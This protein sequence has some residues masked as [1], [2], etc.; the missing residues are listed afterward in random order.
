MTSDMLSSIAGFVCVFCVGQFVFPGTFCKRHGSFQTG[1]HTPWDLSVMPPHGG[2]YLYSAPCCVLPDIPLS[3][4]PSP[5]V[6]TGAVG[7][8]QLLPI[9]QLHS[10]LCPDVHVLLLGRHMGRAEPVGQRFSG[11]AN[12]PSKVLSPPSVWAFRSSQ[13]CLLKRYNQT[14]TPQPFLWVSHG[15]PWGGFSLHVSDVESFCVIICPL[16]FF[17]GEVSV[18]IIYPLFICVVCFLT[19]DDRNFCISQEYKDFIR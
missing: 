9:E 1:F 19:T 3:P 5:P 6:N 7:S 11:N 13:A 18:E 15:A 4:S 17:F 16:T 14:F 10:R 12:T 2:V 8:P